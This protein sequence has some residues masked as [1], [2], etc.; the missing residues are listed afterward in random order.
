MKNEKVVCMSWIDGG[1]FVVPQ[2]VQVE[3][4]DILKVVQYEYDG[5]YSDGKKL[6]KYLKTKVTSFD[7]NKYCEVV[8]KDPVKYNNVILGIFKEYVDK[9]NLSDLYSAEKV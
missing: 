7:D 1:S 4:D 6:D 3:V 5:E 2:L 9:Y 8:V